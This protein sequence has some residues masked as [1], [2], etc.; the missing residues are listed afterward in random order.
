MYTGAGEG[1]MAKAFVAY[2]W[3]L[4]FFKHSADASKE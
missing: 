2:T 4:N 1:I 3:N